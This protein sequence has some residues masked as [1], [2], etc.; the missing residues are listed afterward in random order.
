MEALPVVSPARPLHPSPWSLLGIGAAPLVMA[1]L[2][3]T[4]PADLTLDTARHWTSLHL[5]LIPLFPLIGVNVWWLLA[6]VPGPLAWLARGGAFVYA[7]YYPAVDLLAGVGTGRLVGL[8]VD[9]DSA[10]VAALFRQ[11]NALGDVGNLGLLAAC[12][13]TLAALWPG[14]GRRVVPG[15]VALLLGAWLFTRHHIYPPLGVTGM[16]LLA[17]G[18]VALL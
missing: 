14:V 6:G 10:V 15:G 5:A 7:A 18:F 2:G 8:G 11:E 3:L 12:V 9:E 16:L 4:H 13:L 17:A 1:V